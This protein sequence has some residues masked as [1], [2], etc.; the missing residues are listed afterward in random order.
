MSFDSKYLK[1]YKKAASVCKLWPK[2]MILLIVLSLILSMTGFAVGAVGHLDWLMNLS[3]LAVF[4]CPFGLFFLFF[5]VQRGAGKKLDTL[6]KEL[7]ESKMLA[8]DILTL[9]REQG[10]DLFDVALEARCIH[11]LGMKGVPE[12]CFRD[13]ILPEKKDL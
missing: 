13:G 7:F 6:N 10:I 9:G 8:E 2:R 5:F 3:G 4:V 12:W 1:D 11:E